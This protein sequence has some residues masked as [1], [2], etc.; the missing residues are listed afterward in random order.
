MGHLDHHAEIERVVA[1]DVPPLPPVERRARV[2][3]AGVVGL[4][5]GV[6]RLADEPLGDHAADDAVAGHVVGRRRDHRG[7]VR[8]ALGGLV[9]RP[10]VGEVQSHARL[11]ED[12]LT[13]LQRGLGDDAVHVGMRADPDD[14]D[15]GVGHQL[16]PIVVGALDAELLGGADRGL[17]AAVD[18]AVELDPLG[19]SQAGDVPV[20]DDAARADEANAEGV[21]GHR[22]L[23]FLPGQRP[24]SSRCSVYVL[25]GGSK[26]PP[27]APNF[28][29]RRIGAS[30]VASRKGRSFARTCLPQG[31]G[32]V[33]RP[34]GWRCG[35]QAGFK[36]AP[37]GPTTG[38]EPALFNRA[39]R[40][41]GSCRCGRRTAGTRAA[42]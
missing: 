6:A 23:P 15:P 30:R 25:G 35:D 5:D 29:G 20:A 27:G 8:V 41:R 31:W 36:P 7:L 10:G 19:P 39:S 32:S 42:R 3:V 33:G 38:P 37:S 4:D 9:H 34:Y 11:G 16:L 2:E 26:H 24:T 28:G 40:A 12:V 1:R 14:V 18:H 13:G 21:T 22:A 17:A